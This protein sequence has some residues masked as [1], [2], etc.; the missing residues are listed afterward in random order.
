MHMIS[1]FVM[2]VQGMYGLSEDF[3]ISEEFKEL[4]LKVTLLVPLFEG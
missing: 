4:E 3:V 2:D 1:C